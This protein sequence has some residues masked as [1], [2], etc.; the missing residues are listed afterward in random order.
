MGNV[1]C[2]CFDGGDEESDPLLKGSSQS[3]QKSVASRRRDGTLSPD[4]RPTSPGTLAQS[5]IDRDDA[6]DQ[7]HQDDGAEYTEKRLIERAKREQRTNAV[8]QAKQ[9]QRA[10]RAAALAE[11]RNR[12]LEQRARRQD[13]VQRDKDE[14]RKRLGL[15]PSGFAADNVSIH[16]EDSVQSFSSTRTTK[17]T[18]TS[19]SRASQRSNA[20]TSALPGSTRISPSNSLLD[21]ESAIPDGM[22]SAAAG[23]QSAT[24][25]AGGAPVEAADPDAPEVL[26]IDAGII[27]DQ[28]DAQAT[29]SKAA[30][31]TDA[32]EEAALQH[33][34]TLTVDEQLEELQSTLVDPAQEVTLAELAPA[35]HMLDLAGESAAVDDEAR[36]DS[37]ATTEETVAELQSSLVDPAL[38]VTLSELGHASEESTLAPVDSS[39]EQEPTAAEEESSEAAEP[40][41]N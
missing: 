23:V 6:D 29:D 36:G 19:M 22:S 4:P 2:C 16:S 30:T 13:D 28:G 12:K 7:Q 34:S 27:L 37:A 15:A 18:S 5:R 31:E 1:L 25:V 8:L 9:H 39:A 10:D 20:S 21:M 33:D 11:E 3:G 32:T 17:S 14:R 35:P 40:L 38:E 24:P 26:T 41:S